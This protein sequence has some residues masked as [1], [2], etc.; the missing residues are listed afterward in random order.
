MCACRG[1]KDYIGPA[2]CIV[3]VGEHFALTWLLICFLLAYRPE[4]K[5][6]V[7]EPEV[8]LKF[9]ETEK[10]APPILQ[11]SEVCVCV[12]VGVCGCVL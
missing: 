10:L 7:T 4:L 8:V 12:C 9:P 11:L 3:H 2:T 5:P 6:V 1:T